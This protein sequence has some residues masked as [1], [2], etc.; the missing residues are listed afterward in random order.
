M[1]LFVYFDLLSQGLMYPM[2]T[3]N[4]LYTRGPPGTHSPA[5]VFSVLRLALLMLGGCGVWWEHL[6]KGQ[7]SCE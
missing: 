5:S 7:D 1:L 3:S 2:L 4:L 6:R